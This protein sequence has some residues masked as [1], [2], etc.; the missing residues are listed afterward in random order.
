MLSMLQ[1]EKYNV[2]SVG[3]FVDLDIFS[4]DLQRLSKQRGDAMTA[5]WTIFSIYHQERFN[6][7]AECFFAEPD[8]TIAEQQHVYSPL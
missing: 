3:I 8:I 6:Q 5:E 1:Q 7:L 2:F 4:T